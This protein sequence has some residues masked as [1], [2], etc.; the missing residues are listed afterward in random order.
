M[1]TLAN[2][3]P[4]SYN[5]DHFFSYYSDRHGVG[6]IEAEPTNVRVLI[7]CFDPQQCEPNKNKRHYIKTPKQP[8]TK[9]CLCGKYHTTFTSQR[10]RYNDNSRPTTPTPSTSTA[11]V[12]G[13]TSKQFK[14]AEQLPQSPIKLTGQPTPILLFPSTIFT[15]IDNS[16]PSSIQIAAHSHHSHTCTIC[17]Q[18]NITCAILANN[19]HIHDSTA[20]IVQQRLIHKTCFHN[21]KISINKQKPLNKYHKLYLGIIKYIQKTK[22]QKR[23]QLKQIKLSFTAKRSQPSRDTSN[24]FDWFTTY[25]ITEEMEPYTQLNTHL[26][27]TLFK[28]IQPHLINFK[29]GQVRS[30]TNTQTQTNNTKTDESKYTFKYLLRSLAGLRPTFLT[31]FIYE[32]NPNIDSNIEIPFNILYST[33]TSLL[34]S[35]TETLFTKLNYKQI[36]C[37]HTNIPPYSIPNRNRIA[38]NF[39]RL[40]LYLNHTYKT[41]NSTQFFQDLGITPLR[42][43]LHYNLKDDQPNKPLL[44]IR[45][46][47]KFNIYIDLNIPK[48]SFLD[49]YRTPSLNECNLSFEKWF[50]SFFES[51]SRQF[52]IINKQK[53]MNYIKYQI[54]LQLSSYL[55][56]LLPSQ[57]EFNRPTSLQDRSKQTTKAT[58]YHLHICTYSTTQK[59]ALIS[60]DQDHDFSTIS[61]TIFKQ[62]FQQYPAPQDKMDIDNEGK[63]GI[64]HPTLNCSIF[65]ADQPHQAS[66]KIP[67]PISLFNELAEKAEKEYMTLNNT[68]TTNINR[69]TYYFYTYFKAFLNA[70]ALNEEIINLNQQEAVKK[71]SKETTDIHFLA[72]I[73]TYYYIQ[74]QAR[75]SLPQIR[76]KY[77]TTFYPQAQQ[78]IYDNHKISFQQPKQIN[79]SLFFSSQLPHSKTSLTDS[80]NNNPNDNQSEETIPSNHNSPKISYADITTQNF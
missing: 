22:Q 68:T 8:C 53:T 33:F 24:D 19:K 55:K 70:A 52:I 71:I 9:T 11:P 39:A 42:M 74:N 64:T 61:N 72:R 7:A 5:I 20:I 44:L 59:C 58:L 38:L 21:M 48:Q 60:T 78:I 26:A 63:P 13:I 54:H 37:S 34:G 69:Q 40:H 43:K 18:Q 15:S 66:F 51:Y 50:N 16:D 67:T 35:F 14:N 25:P 29:P 77:K 6:F 75:A 79:Q 80:N 41:I 65:Q 23:A 30:Q 27:I 45:N 56:N 31:Q 17:H 2:T 1:P 32:A 57:F 12:T 3:N 36:F 46:D 47:P 76:S 4:D 49:T 10:F 62:S 73:I 28:F